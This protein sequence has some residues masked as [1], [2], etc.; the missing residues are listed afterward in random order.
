MDYEMV[1]RSIRALI[2][3]EK[4]AYELSRLLYAHD[5]FYLLSLLKPGGEYGGKLNKQ[6]VIGS[7]ETSVRY[8]ACDTVFE[9]LNHKIPY[10]VVKGA[11]LS[12]A[13]YSGAAFANPE[14]IDLLGEQ[15]RYDR[16]KRIL[17][18]NGFVQGQYRSRP[19]RF[20]PRK[21][22]LF[23]SSLTHSWPPFVGGHLKSAL[24]VC[25]RRCKHRH[26]WGES[27]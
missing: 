1:V 19:N 9:A 20:V 13:A 3:G 2:R 17:L 21:E 27:G 7:I 22:L 12:M 11:P 18:D 15:E 16:V 5:C 6:M 26:F 24:P 23:F 14:Y 4:P 8:T 25:E 10:A